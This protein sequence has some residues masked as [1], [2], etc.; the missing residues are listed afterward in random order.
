MCYNKVNKSVNRFLTF[1]LCICICKY[2]DACPE[3]VQTKI[4]ETMLV[5]TYK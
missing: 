3:T 2:K 4:I 1:I 5:C